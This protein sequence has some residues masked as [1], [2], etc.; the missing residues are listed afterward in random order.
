MANICPTCMANMDMVGRSH[1]CI[2]REPVPDQLR[3]QKEP[4]DSRTRSSGGSTY[5]YRDPDSR[6]AY[7]RDYMKRKRTPGGV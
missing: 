6:R 2:A 7:M 4:L 5:Q 1:R 3:D